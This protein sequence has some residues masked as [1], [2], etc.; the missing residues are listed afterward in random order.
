VADNTQ[1]TYLTQEQVNALLAPDSIITIRINDGIPS[2]AMD[3]NP[4]DAPQMVQRLL[5]MAAALT[6]AGSAARH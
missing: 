1:P 2:A 6:Q 5:S 3:V 4:S